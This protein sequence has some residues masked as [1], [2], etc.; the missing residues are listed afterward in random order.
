MNV[1]PITA[2]PDYNQR[3]LLEALAFFD[4]DRQ[5]PTDGKHAAKKVRCLERLQESLVIMI[6]EAKSEACEHC[7][8]TG[9]ILTGHRNNPASAQSC[10]DCQWRFEEVERLEGVS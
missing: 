7:H 4:R 10:E 6:L 2:L 5:G 1:G 9:E 3:L 8:G